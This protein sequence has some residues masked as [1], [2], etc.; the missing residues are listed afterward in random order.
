MKAKPG[1]TGKGPGGQRTHKL[2]STLGSGS[3]Y[4]GNAAKSAGSE[5]P[6]KSVK[7]PVRG[8]PATGKGKPAN[9]RKK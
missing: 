6:K 3:R 2:M 4:A 5:G 7:G 1:S 9:K 8:G